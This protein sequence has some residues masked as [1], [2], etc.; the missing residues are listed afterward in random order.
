MIGQRNVYDLNLELVWRKIILTFRPVEYI[1]MRDSDSH[2]D[3][4][5]DSLCSLVIA[6]T[7]MQVTNI[8]VNLRYGC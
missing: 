2:S 7:Q 8:N 4:D 5:S 1:T 3:T 6:E